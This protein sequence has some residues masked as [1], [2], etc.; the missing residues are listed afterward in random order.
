M[1]KRNAAFEAGSGSPTLG[2]KNMGC[3]RVVCVDGLAERS[4]RR[5]EEKGFLTR[6]PPIFETCNVP[7]SW[8][9]LDG[10]NAQ[11]TLFPPDLM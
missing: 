7:R 11:T 4:V 10:H 1:Q 5:Y 8:H 2:A 9:P 6:S 3:V